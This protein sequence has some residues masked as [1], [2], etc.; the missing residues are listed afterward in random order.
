MV[1]QPCCGGGCVNE[2]DR[3]RL[4]RAWELL[5]L[6]FS[7]IVFRSEAPFVRYINH[8]GIIMMPKKQKIAPQRRRGVLVIVLSRGQ[9][10]SASKMIPLTDIKNPG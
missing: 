8:D 7:R 3:R 5:A 9:F 2:A 1:N 10:P 4:A 6:S